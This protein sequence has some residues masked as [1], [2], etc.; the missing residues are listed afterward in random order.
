MK[1][2]WDKIFDPDSSAPLTSEEEEQSWQELL[3]AYRENETL[4]A[5]PEHQRVM[6]KIEEQL[7]RAEPTE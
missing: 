7:R 6:H 3:I 2:T 4:L 1:T 5:A